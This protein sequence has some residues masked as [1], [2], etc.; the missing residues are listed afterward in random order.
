[1]MTKKIRLYF[2]TSTL[3]KMFNPKTVEGV[4]MVNGTNN[5]NSPKIIS[6]FSFNDVKNAADKTDD[7]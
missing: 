1:M 6:P 4:W 2:D 3:G 5:Y 7:Y